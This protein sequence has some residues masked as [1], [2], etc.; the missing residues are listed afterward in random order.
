M[1]AIPI[2]KEYLN[3]FEEHRMD[4]SEYCK[5]SPK[6]NTQEQGDQYSSSR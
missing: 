2:K 6:Q 4:L 3:H 1:K 5:Y